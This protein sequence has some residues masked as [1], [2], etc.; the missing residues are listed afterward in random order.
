[1]RETMSSSAKALSKFIVLHQVV[2]TNPSTVALAC[3]M[4]ALACSCD[5]D[6]KAFAFAMAESTHNQRLLAMREEINERDTKLHLLPEAGRAQSLALALAA[7]VYARLSALLG[8][9]D[10]IPALACEDD[11][12]TFELARYGLLL[13]IIA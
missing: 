11:P 7:L 10:I 5:D 4:C 3:F 2:S 9:F 1:M 8:E 6:V 12:Q 13:F